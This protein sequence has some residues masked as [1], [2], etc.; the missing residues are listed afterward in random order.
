MWSGWTGA[1]L[2]QV[3][4]KWWGFE[5]A[6]PGSDSVVV[7]GYYKLIDWNEQRIRAN[8]GSIHLDNEVVTVE[9]QPDGE[10]HV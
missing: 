3:S 8:G 10:S 9:Q 6:F 1:R 2:S 7:P 5:H 4:L